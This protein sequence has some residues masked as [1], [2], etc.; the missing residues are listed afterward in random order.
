[1]EKLSLKI[2]IHRSNHAR[3]IGQKRRGEEKKLKPPDRS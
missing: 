3:V 2:L 1:V